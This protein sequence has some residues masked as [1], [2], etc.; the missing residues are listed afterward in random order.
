[1][2]AETTVHGGHVKHG[3][4]DS[5]YVR[6]YKRN[7]KGVTKDFVEIIFPGD[8][9]TVVNRQ[10][11][12]DDTHR[13]PKHWQAYQTG[14]EVKAS[15]FPLEQWPE[16]AT[17]EGLLRDLNH[18]HIYTVEQLAAVSDQNLANIG[19]GARAL[20]AK[21]QAFLAVQKDSGAV[22]RYAAQYE[23]V[24]EENALLKRQLAEL[25]ARLQAIEDGAATGEDKPRRGRPPKA[26]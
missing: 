7:E 19:L 8:N 22:A 15:G 12:E 11:K 10:V 17:D 24:S 26:D 20:V 4:D 16:I 5:A 25:S 18:K 23:Q 2:F 21:A 14:E 3:S 1:M 13:W 6:F 9:K